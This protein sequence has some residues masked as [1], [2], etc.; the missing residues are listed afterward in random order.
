MGIGKK[1]REHFGWLWLKRE[2]K[3]ERQIC[4]SCV[5]VKKL[6]GILILE[7]M[8]MLFNDRLKKA[9]KKEKEIKRK[10]KEERM[11]KRKRRKKMVK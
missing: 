1:P 2:L 8:T 9:Q 3:L 4:L 10:I 7:N 5:L 11:E 6:N